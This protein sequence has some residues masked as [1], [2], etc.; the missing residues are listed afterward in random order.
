ME[1][2][3]TV[4]ALPVED[5][6]RDL[7]KQWRSAVEEDS[8]EMTIF[9]PK[10]LGSGYVRGTSF[11]SGVGVIQYNC[12]FF[13]VYEIR[14]SVL[15]IH[16]LKFIFCSE[17]IVQHTFE[18]ETELHSIYTHQNVIVSSSG[19]NGHVLT[20]LANRKCQVTSIEIIRDVFANRR[21]YNYKD[22]DPVLRSLFEDS[23]SR[24]RFFYQGNYSL[25]AA[26][27]VGTI[28]KKQYKGFLRTTFLEGKTLELLAL[29][30][31]QYLDDQRADGT[32]QMIRRSELKK[33]EM[34]VRLIEEN[35]GINYT[36][37]EL[38][39]EVG[40]NV[41]KLQEG[42]RILFGLTVKKYAQ[43]QKFEA[44]RELLEKR[45]ANISEIVRNLGLSNRS[46]FSKVFKE[47][48]GVSPSY[49][50]HTRDE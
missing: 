2:Q 38:A 33:I 29:Q 45:D 3:V 48:Y 47:K 23:D 7:G 21:N 13:K 8:G 24:K 10:E 6:I 9:L 28:E 27:I 35:I 1:G 19:K 49:F 18:D 20:F 22:L 30:I 43:D 44:A 15:Q 26:E 4:K 40:T 34:A 11:S 25:K 17:G 42:F 5:I 41:N 14:F 50:Q 36:V 16:P 39:N 12:T 37:E 32:P 46:Y 31:I